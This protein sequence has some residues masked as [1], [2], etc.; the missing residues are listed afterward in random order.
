MYKP[1]L[2][3]TIRKRAIQKEAI[4]ENNKNIIFEFLRR[5]QQPLYNQNNP[6]SVWRELWLFSPCQ[7]RDGLE[8]GFT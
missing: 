6:S 4:F 7:S 2:L 1:G 8:S 5:I 3:A